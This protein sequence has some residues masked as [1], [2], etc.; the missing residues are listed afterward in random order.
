MCNSPSW[1]TPFPVATGEGKEK[2]V[3]LISASEGGRGQYNKKSVWGGRGSRRKKKFLL[4]NMGNGW[5]DH[6]SLALLQWNLDIGSYTIVN[7]FDIVKLS[8]DDQIFSACNVIIIVQWIHLHGSSTVLHY[9]VVLVY[10]FFFMSSCLLVSLLS[11]NF[12]KSPAQKPSFLPA[13]FPTQKKISSV[14]PW[15]TRTNT[16]TCLF[17]GA[18]ALSCLKTS[19]IKLSYGAV[20][21]SLLVT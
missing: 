9:P 17:P 14:F 8:P 5:L 19:A 13:P 16:I 10:M 20:L 21:K 15:E 18:A 4:Q 7:F 3:Q 2:R 6:L 11:A 12:D 1:R